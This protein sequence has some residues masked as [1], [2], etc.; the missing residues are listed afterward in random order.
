MLIILIFVHYTT[1]IVY[2]AYCMKDRQYKLYIAI[3]LR[4]TFTSCVA[5]MHG[6]LNKGILQSCNKWHIIYTPY[7]IRSMMKVSNKYNKG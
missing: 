5:K 1:R 2:N 7:I 6:T 3:V 4:V